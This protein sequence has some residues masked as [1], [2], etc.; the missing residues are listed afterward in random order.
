MNCLDNVIGIDR[1]CTPVTPSSGLYIQDLPGISLKI[2]NAAIDEETVSGISLIEEKISFAQ[3]AILAQ[4]RNSLANKV[5]VKSIIENDT[6]GYYQNNLQPIP[7]EAGKYK[8]IKASINNYPHLDFFIGKIY[9]QLNAVV[10]TNILIIDLMT[11][12][13]LD[14]LPITTTA[15][16]PTAVIV[17]KS[18]SAKRQKQALL[19][20]IDSEVAGSY[21]TN[22]TASKCSSC[23]DSGYSNKYISFSGSQISKVSQKIE[24]NLESNN[25]T[26]GLSIEYSLNCSLENFLCTMGNQLAWAL[27]HKVGSELMRELKYSRRLNSIV[28]LDRE[29]N[30]KMLE[31]FEAEY[32]ASMSAIINNIKV[33]NDICFE[34]NSRIRQTTVIP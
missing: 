17:N 2:A 33:P 13:I 28:V 6:I 21:K 7:L 14:T 30:E 25:G 18:Y 15:N 8:G 1:K 4:L 19:I 11:G 10:T 20:C 31:D 29:D 3:N 24:S 12:E 16:I 23:S 26:N 34:C 32:M 9:L 5:R 27:L 22:V